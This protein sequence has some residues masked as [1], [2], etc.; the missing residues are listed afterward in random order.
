[1][2]NLWTTTKVRPVAGSYLEERPRR[3][4]HQRVASFIPLPQVPVLQVPVLQVTRHNPPVP[5]KDKA[6]RII[7]EVTRRREALNR[8][9]LL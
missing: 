5:Y 1:M 3:P 8:R 4:V 2:G 9:A 6:L 7:H